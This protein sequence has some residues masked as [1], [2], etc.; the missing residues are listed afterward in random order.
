M[1]HVITSV[2]EWNDSYIKENLSRNRLGFVPTMGAL[3]RGHVS[4]IKQSVTENQKTVVSIFVNPT[5]FND[6]NDLQKYPKTFDQDLHLMNE[7]GADYLFFPNYN[8]LYPD[9]FAYK[10]EEDSFS[11]LLCGAHRQGHFTGV[12]TVVLKLL[13]II[14]AGKAYFGEK[15]YQQFKLIQEMAK[16]FFLPVD[17]VACPT[18]RDEDGLALSSRNVHLSPAERTFALHFPRLLQSNNSCKQIATKLTE[19]GF[20]V[21]YIEEYDG[22][23]FGAVHVGKVRLIDNVKV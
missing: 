4:L 12:L 8:E 13:N 9:N 19:L 6:P 11:K 2:N 3:H 16:T 5:Q 7:V 21:D 10:V 17:I 23:R 18:V 14:K 22:R 1:T 15:D 20:I